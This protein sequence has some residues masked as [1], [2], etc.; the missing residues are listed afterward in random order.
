MQTSPN[1]VVVF[2]FKHQHTQTQLHPWADSQKI[3]QNPNCERWVFARVMFQCFLSFV[4]V[5]LI[6]ILECKQK[7]VV[8]SFLFDGLSLDCSCNFE[9]L[10]CFVFFLEFI[11]GFMPK[12]PKIQNDQRGLFFLRVWVLGLHSVQF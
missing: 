8:Y 6:N 2:V 7:K 11:C 9:K 3:E 1:R 5:R 4:P 10:F 12:H